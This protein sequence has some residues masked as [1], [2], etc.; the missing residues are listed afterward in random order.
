V[1]SQPTGVSIGV[2]R[3]SG[4]RSNER[5]PR[6]VEKNKNAWLLDGVELAKGDVVGIYWDL[7][8]SPVLSFSINGVMNS[9]TINKIRPTIDLFPLIKLEK[10]STCKLNFKASGF[11][12]PPKKEKF[13]PIICASSLI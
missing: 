10:G 7:T 2:I 1:L 13:G 6:N 12:H 8:D 3:F 4:K 9:F 5:L 11:R